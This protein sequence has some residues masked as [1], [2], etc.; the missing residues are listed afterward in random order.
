MIVI[1]GLEFFPWVMTWSPLGQVFA[2]RLGAYTPVELIDTFNTET[3]PFYHLVNGGN[4]L[5]YNDMGMPAWAQFSCCT[6]PSAMVGL[7]LRRQDV[8][9]T[10]YDK[11]CKVVGRQFGA[12]AEA[13]AR[14]WEGLI[15][16]SEYCGVATSKADTV[17][18]FSMFS[19][20]DN[21]RLGIRSKALAMVAYGARFQ[22]GTTQYDNKSIRSHT[23]F[24]PL[25]ILSV[26]VPQHTKPDSTFLYQ[27]D[28]IDAEGL[29]EIALT[30]NSAIQ[31]RHPEVEHLVQVRSPAQASA[32]IE[33][34]IANL[35]P[36]TIVS[37]GLDPG[38]PPVLHL[39]KSKLRV[40][41]SAPMPP[42]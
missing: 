17:V 11:L 1:G 19:L 40:V 3:L 34:L 23:R 8:D 21:L 6:M 2:D 42:G 25:E 27:L 33:E 20:L 5:V 10:L 35:G 12:R 9:P 26:H 32:A 31:T 15:P 16:V 36:M 22:L 4:N 29:M 41:D 7:A 28:L 13:S 37:P 24:G 39:A 14:A 30:G 18:G 38:D